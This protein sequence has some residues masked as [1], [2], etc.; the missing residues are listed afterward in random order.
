MRLGLLLLTLLGS[1]S[2]LPQR[3]DAQEIRSPYRYIDET[4]AVGGFVGFFIGEPGNPGVGPHSGIMFGA[5]YT[6]R[7][8]GPLSGEI[9]LSLVPTEREIIAFDTIADV[10]VPTGQMVDMNVGL[11]EGGLRFHLTG[12]RAWNGMA[13]FVI[14]TGGI[15]SNLSGAS[16]ADATLPADQRFRMGQSFTVGFGGG[17]DVFVGERFSL[18][19]EA[20]DHIL[21]LRIPAGLTEGQRAE[22]MWTN[23]FGLSLGA[24]LHF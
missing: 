23:N 4:N 14:L 24:A 22:S 2:L 21:R 1:V 9:N 19:L 11:L 5:R 7:F 20:R 16:A 13:P 17:T 15:A 8:S 6:T 3:L 12:P 10:I 18:R